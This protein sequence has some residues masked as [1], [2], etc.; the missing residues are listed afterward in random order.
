VLLQA[1][2]QASKQAIVAFL[3]CVQELVDREKKLQQE[4]ATAKLAASDVSRERDALHAK[5]DQ[6]K[7]VGA[8]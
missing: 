5:L 3:F 6:H 7:Q 2:K 8:A 1:S 4:L